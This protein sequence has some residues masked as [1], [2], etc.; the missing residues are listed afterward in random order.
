MGWIKDYVQGV[1]TKGHCG[2][3][4]HGAAASPG[5]ACRSAW[6]PCHKASAGHRRGAHSCDCPR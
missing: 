5:C 1:S 6:C 2:E 3:C 4:G